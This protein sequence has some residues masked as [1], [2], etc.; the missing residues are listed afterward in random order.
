VGDG[1]V[2]DVGV[3]VAG[4]A[5][6]GDAVG[7]EEGVG[8][9]EGVGVGVGVGLAGVPPVTA[10]VEALHRFSAFAPLSAKTRT[11]TNDPASAATG[12]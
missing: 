6:L 11:D 12:R 5:G 1:V 2:V 3:G 4:D 9:A 10:T 7:V 8:A